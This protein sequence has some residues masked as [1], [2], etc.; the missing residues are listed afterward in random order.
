[1]SCICSLGKSV[2]LRAFQVWM[3]VHKDENFPCSVGFR[4]LMCIRLFYFNENV[5]SSGMTLTYS[6]AIA[7]I[8]EGLIIASGYW[9]SFI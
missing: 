7:F 9:K 5:V 3:L 1:M 2:V 8:V 6:L 4:I